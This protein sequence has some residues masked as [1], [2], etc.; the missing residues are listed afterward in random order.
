MRR[1]ALVTGGNRGIGLAICRQ[2]ARQ[3]MEVVLTSRD[4]AA[5]EQAAEALRGEGLAVRAAQ[6]DVDDPESVRRCAAQ[7]DVVDVLVNNAAILV[8]S[9]LSVFDVDEALLRQTMETN[10]YG[11]L[12]TCRAWVP[13]MRAGGVA[14]FS[15][16]CVTRRD[17]PA[18]PAVVLRRRPG[19]A[20]D[21]PPRYGAGARRR[22][23]A[24]AP[25]PAWAW[26]AD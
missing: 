13:G 25:R 3:G 12:R 22:I 9:G 21:E 4:A 11:P 6:L 18:N 1:T 14:T 20:G 5:G 15:R 23:L 10:F 8:D 16:S 17:S 19:T 24:C 26:R 7:V 2:L